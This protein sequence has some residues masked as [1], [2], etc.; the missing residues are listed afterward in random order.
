MRWTI[1]Y[2]DALRDKLLGTSGST[3]SKMKQL[4]VECFALLL[5]RIGIRHTRQNSIYYQFAVYPTPEHIERIR[6]TTREVRPTWLIN[7]V[8]GLNPITYK[9]DLRDITDRRPKMWCFASISK[10][11]R[12]VSVQGVM[13]PGRLA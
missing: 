7:V 5:T 1:A 12:R 6:K 2:D 13:T 9:L 8:V 3:Y 11:E 4:G 10:K